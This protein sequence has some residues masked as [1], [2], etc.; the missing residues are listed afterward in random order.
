MASN[1]V[2]L[3][4]QEKEM[5]FLIKESKLA[6]L[7]LQIYIHSKLCPD[8]D[9]SLNIKNIFKVIQNK[10]PG[11]I[12]SISDIFKILCL[13]NLNQSDL[14]FIG[15]TVKNSSEFLKIKE[16]KKVAGIALYKKI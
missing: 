4:F 1:R 13:N 5:D 6:G 7:P 3:T 16:I 8:F 2:Y 15:K 10:E 14:A 9:L 12:F 11:E